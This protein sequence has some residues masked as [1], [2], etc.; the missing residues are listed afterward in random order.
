M[1]VV[2]SGVYMRHS[3]GLGGDPEDP[4]SQP[5]SCS[6][7]DALPIPAFAVDSACRAIAWNAAAERAYGW[8]R[9]EVLDEAAPFASAAARAVLA[10]AAASVRAG[11]ARHFDLPFVARDGS[12]R[13]ARIQGAGF[14]LDGEPGGI[15]F[16][17]SGGIDRSDLERRDPFESDLLQTVLDAIPTPIW[18]KTIDGIYRGCNLAFEQALGKTR[19]ELIGKTV[20]AA[21][22]SRITGVYRNADTAL[23]ASGGTQRYEGELQTGEGE[24]RRVE[25]HKAVFR[26]QSGSVIGL[27]GT[28]IDITDLRRTE[29]DLRRALEVVHHAESRFSQLVEASPDLVF[30]HREGRFLYANPSFATLAGRSAAEL[31]GTSVLD[32]VHPEDRPALRERLRASGRLHAME[33]RLVGAGGRVT[34]VEFISAEVQMPDG[35]ARVSIGRDLTER[36]RAEDRLHRADRLAALGTLAAGVAHELNNPLSFV[37]S[38]AEW[39]VERLTR[40]AGPSACE[41]TEVVR[42]LGDVVQGAQRMKVIVSDLRTAA[43]DESAS[44]TLA[45]IDLRRVV[46]FAAQLTGGELRRRARLV[47]DADPV[48]PVFGSETRLGQVL[49]NLLV[50]AAHAMPAE[51]LD[52]NEIRVRLRPEPDGRVSISVSDNGCGIA[53]S[54]RPRLFE[55]FFTT[56]PVGEGTG[57]GLWVCHGIVAAHGGEIEVESELGKGTT[58]RVLLPTTQALQAGARTAPPTPPH[59]R[60]SPAPL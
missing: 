18:F 60:A 15:V 53:D 7:F 56:K 25:F 22:P 47:V 43:R 28:L 34:P 32:W 1:W 52:R 27:A 35:P 33:G 17:D 36:K 13:R 5:L 59:G 16:V 12:S 20:A 3:M 2:P 55:P 57:L 31:A 49:V 30:I 58:F 11:E 26:D 46:E 41:L 21:G 37:L 50:N 38:N 4:L 24:L 19:D 54:V 44:D 40:T 45:A 48:P 9:A 29:E 39:A 51:G 10:R 14:A 8:S 6:L 42:A 23:F